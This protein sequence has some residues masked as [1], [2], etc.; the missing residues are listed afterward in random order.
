MEMLTLTSYYM[1]VS[2]KVKLTA[3]IRHNDR[4]SKSSIPIYSSKAPEKLWRKRRR[5][6]RR[7]AVA[8]RY[9]LQANTKIWILIKDSWNHHTM[10]ILFNKFY[11]SFKSMLLI[12]IKF[13]CIVHF[14][15]KIN[16]WFWKLAVV[17]L[18]KRHIC[19]LT[20]CFAF[21]ALQY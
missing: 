17:K 19:Q 1:N 4:F 15:L 16:W 18:A 10:K 2:E 7:K 12:N 6:K 9:S 20:L 13:I 3:S 21:L 5:R 8:E 14:L 11:S